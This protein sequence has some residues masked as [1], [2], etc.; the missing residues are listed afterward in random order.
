MPSRKT[1][2]RILLEQQVHPSQPD[3]EYLPSGEVANIDA[4]WAEELLAR[5]DAEPLDAQAGDYALAHGRFDS[6]VVEPEGAEESDDS[7]SEAESVGE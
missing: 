5:G 1:K 4:G 7:D 2:V 3:R 6:Q